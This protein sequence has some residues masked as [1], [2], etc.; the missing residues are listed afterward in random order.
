M[1]IEQLSVFV[2]NAPG[3]LL[4]VLEILRDAGIDMRALSIADTEQFGVLRLIVDN[5]PQAAASLGKA[6]YV[7]SITP[8][9]A[10]NLE[11]APGSLVKMVRLLADAAISIEYLYAFAARK[12]NRAYV[13]FRVADNA[14]AEAVLEAGGVQAAGSEEIHDALS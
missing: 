13:V 14:R 12:K 2:E 3:R 8:V 10:V 5:P 9:L 1:T 7:V 11:D 4:E 6:G